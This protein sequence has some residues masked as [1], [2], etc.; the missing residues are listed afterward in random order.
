M[1]R[2]FTAR[3]VTYLKNIWDILKNNSFPAVYLIYRVS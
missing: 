3:K 1:G 2:A